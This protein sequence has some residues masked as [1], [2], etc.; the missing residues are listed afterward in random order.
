MLFFLFHSW[1]METCIAWPFMYYRRICNGIN[2]KLIIYFAV[3]C[4]V[5]AHSNNGTLPAHVGSC[6]IIIMH[7][8][9]SNA[10]NLLSVLHS[11][12]IVEGDAVCLLNWRKLWLLNPNHG[13][14]MGV[15]VIVYK[16]LYLWWSTLKCFFVFFY[17]SMVSPSAQLKIQS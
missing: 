15:W 14:K 10:S 4:L 1:C 16:S 7:D 5:A 11:S 3:G 6:S 12:L 2:R 9:V 8:K 17:V 13:A